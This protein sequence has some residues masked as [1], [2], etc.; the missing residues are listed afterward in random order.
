MLPERTRHVSATTTTLDLP[1]E[2]GAPTARPQSESAFTDN[3]VLGLEV[4][5]ENVKPSLMR[6]LTLTNWNPSTD[7]ISLNDE[8]PRA[9]TSVLGAPWVG[10]GAHTD[11]P[12]L[13]RVIEGLNSD[14]GPEATQKPP[15]AHLE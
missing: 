7:A 8:T 3:R 12:A 9:V 13:A 11:P 15:Q 6:T 10:F 2:F 5:G 1:D 4:D 14:G